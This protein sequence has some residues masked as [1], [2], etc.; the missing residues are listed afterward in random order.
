MWAAFFY[1]TCMKALIVDLP[2]QK[3]IGYSTE[4]S[5]AENT[6]KFLWEKAMIQFKKELKVEHFYSVQEYPSNYFTN[7]SPS[8][9]FRKWALADADLVG[10]W[11][12]SELFILPGGTFAKF[13][14]E[15]RSK[16]GFFF[17]WLYQE[18]LP[19][20]EYKL[21]EAPHFEVL[22]RLWLQNVELSEQVYVPIAIK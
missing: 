9:K 10:P 13:G 15:D 20:S 14:I 11:S 18:W 4:M 17:K 7:F 3:L 22:P 2:S 5:L 8:C 21:R 19:N 12:N 16:A 1:L 6:T